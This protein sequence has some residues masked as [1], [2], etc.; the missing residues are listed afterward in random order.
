MRT[1]IGPIYFDILISIL[2]YLILGVGGGRERERR[3][4]RSERRHVYFPALHF[5][6]PKRSVNPDRF[7]VWSLEFEFG[8]DH[9]SRSAAL[10]VSSEKKRWRY[11]VLG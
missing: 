4:R 9:G 10:H 2:F 5:P 11:L 8:G 3:R 7:G 6:L 1:C